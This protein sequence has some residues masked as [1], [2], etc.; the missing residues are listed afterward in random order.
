[1]SVT[2]DEDDR[3]EDG[4]AL[5]RLDYQRPWYEGIPRSV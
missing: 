3:D 2:R 1:M 5:E 4:A